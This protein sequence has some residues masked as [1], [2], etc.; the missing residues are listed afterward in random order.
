M[1]KKTRETRKLKSIHE[2]DFAERK[3]QGRN[4]ESLCPETSTKNAVLEFNGISV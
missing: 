2:L 3:N 1:Y 4:P